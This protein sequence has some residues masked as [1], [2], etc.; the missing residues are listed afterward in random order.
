MLTVQG[1]KNAQKIKP[2]FFGLTV[3][4][5]EK[6]P[7]FWL[8]PRKFFHRNFS[9]TPFG[10]AHPPIPKYTTRRRAQ[11]VCNTSSPILE[12]RRF[13]LQ[14]I[15]EQGSAR[16]RKR[17]TRRRRLNTACSQLAWVRFF[18]ER[19]T[20]LTGESTASSR[21]L[22]LIELAAG[23]QSAQL[24]LFLD[25]LRCPRDEFSL[26]R[27]LLIDGR[28]SRWLSDALLSVATQKT[29]PKLGSVWRLKK[30][31]SCSGIPA[32]SF[33]FSAE[34]SENFSVLNWKTTR[35][36]WLILPVVICLSQRLSHACLS[37]SLIK[38]KP[39]MAH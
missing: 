28:E 10:Q 38:V 15:C 24:L 29:K 33:E 32:S 7:E 39:R 35:V 2:W 1:F 11:Y 6:F 23:I 22:V 18:C 12:Q 31:E 21:I 25:G 36:T 30:L 13:Y 37:T 16:E 27:E 8:S 3:P 9:R 14:D 4:F 19:R 34:N 5:S 20:P 26:I 17:K